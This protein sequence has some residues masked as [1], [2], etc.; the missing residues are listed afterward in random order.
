[1]RGMVATHNAVGDAQGS[2]HHGI[3]S[4]FRLDR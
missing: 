3:V 4:S 2:D 1:V